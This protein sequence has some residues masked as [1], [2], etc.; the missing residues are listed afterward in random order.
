MECI[1]Q[2]IVEWCFVY[3]LAGYLDTV[4]LGLDRLVFFVCLSVCLLVCLPVCLLY[5]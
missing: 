2:E 5:A 1:A 3:I 4:C